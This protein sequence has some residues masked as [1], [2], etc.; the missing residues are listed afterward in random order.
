MSSGHASIGGVIA[1][2][3]VASVFANAEDPF[4]HGITYGG[5]PVNAAIALKNLEIMKRERILEHVNEMAPIFRSKLET[6]LDLP[7]VGDVRGEGFFY[8]IELVSDP[9]T[10]G[11]FSEEESA[12]VIKGFISQQLYERGLICRTD[13][14]ADP[15]LMIS[16]P[17]VAG[18][19]E[20]DEIVRVIGGVLEDAWPRLTALR[21]EQA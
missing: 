12:T 13:D 9:E 17:L 11:S 19:D 15:V 4:M 2:D 10:C 7:L 5:H 16:P 21:S 1:S 3:R 14:R 6:L 18:L 8:A 20:F